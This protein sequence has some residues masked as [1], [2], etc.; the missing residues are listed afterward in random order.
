MPPMNGRAGKFLDEE[1]FLSEYPL[2][3]PIGFLEVTYKY[4]RHIFD[5]MFSLLTNK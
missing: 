3:G 5:C 4:I 1:R 2:Q